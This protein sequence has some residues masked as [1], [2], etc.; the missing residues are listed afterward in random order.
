MKPLSDT[1]ID[2]IIKTRLEQ[3]PRNGGTT[4]SKKVAWNQ[5]ELELIDSVIMDYLTKKGY[6]RE[7]TAQTIKERWDVHLSTARRYVKDTISRMSDAV[8]E[9]T[10]KMRKLWLERVENV[11][12]SAIATGNKEAAIRSLDLMAKSM[13]LYR[14]NVNISGGDTPIKFDFQ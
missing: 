13:G 8:E 2:Y 9:D 11:L 12:E 6:S 14:E 7:R 5:D 1:E 4:S 3:F 10:D